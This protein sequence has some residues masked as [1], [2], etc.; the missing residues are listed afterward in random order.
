MIKLEH[1]LC[2]RNNES[3]SES[4]QIRFIF[5]TWLQLSLLLFKFHKK[6]ST[7]LI[8]QSQNMGKNGKFS[9]IEIKFD[10]RLSI[11]QQPLKLKFFPHPFRLRVNTMLIDCEYDQ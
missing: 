1:D 10:V 11:Y 2:S 9:R 7:F 4:Y 6:Y 8:I 3:V 5:A